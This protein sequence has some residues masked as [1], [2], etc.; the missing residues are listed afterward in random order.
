MKTESPGGLSKGPEPDPFG[1]PGPAGPSRSPGG[2]LKGAAP[3]DPVQEA[4]SAVRALR[5][6]PDEQTKQRA[7]V[8][9]ERALRRLKEAK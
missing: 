5:E 3:E 1:A 4:E 6:A 9:L 7:T 8:A 2:L